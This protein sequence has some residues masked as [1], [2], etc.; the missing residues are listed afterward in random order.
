[1]KAGRANPKMLDRIEIE[2]YGS[3]MPLNQVAGISAPEPRVLLI[4]PWIRV[5]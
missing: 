3:M 5:Q 4:Q 1:M 2:C